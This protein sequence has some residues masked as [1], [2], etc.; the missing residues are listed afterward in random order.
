MGRIIFMTPFSRMEIIGGIKTNYQHAVLLAELGYDAC[1][2]QPDGQSKW[3]KSSS[4]ASEL[5][6]HDHSVA[7][8]PSP[9]RPFEEPDRIVAGSRDR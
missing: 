1:I 9:I 5:C 8:R 4:G 2:Y 6:N 7:A 3:F